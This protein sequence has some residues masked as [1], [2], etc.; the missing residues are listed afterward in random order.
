MEANDLL[1]LDDM[2]KGIEEAK[3]PERLSNAWDKVNGDFKQRRKGKSQLLIVGTRWSVHDPLTRLSEMYENNPR[4]RF[5]ILPALNENDESNFD[6]DYDVGFST[7]YYRQ[8]REETSDKFYWLCVYQQEPI[9]REGLGFPDDELKYYNGVLPDNI[10]AVVAVCDSKGT[11]K[12]FV[13]MP[14]AYVSGQDVFIPDVVF[15]DGMPD[16]TTP[17]VADKCIKHKVSRLDIEMNNG[18]DYFGSKTSALIKQGGGHT[19][20]RIFFTSSNKIVRI[21]T[22]SDFIKEHFF[23]LDKEHQNKEYKAFMKNVTTYVVT[24][25]NKHD[26]GPDGLSLLSQLVKGLTQGQVKIIDRRKLPF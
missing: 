22:E 17:K 24:G 9:E 21:N 14:I 26:D 19:S 11:G 18:G 8:V 1:Y 5:K 15:D 4:A 25:K 6:Y 23:F 10:D 2:I 16:K 3:N 20:I 13:S 12:D 7:L